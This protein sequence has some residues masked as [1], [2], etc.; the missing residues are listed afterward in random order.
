MTFT[1]ANIQGKQTVA[2]PT[3]A[4]RLRQHKHGQVLEQE[5]RNLST[6]V[7]S[8]VAVQVVDKNGNPITEGD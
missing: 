2:V 6:G 7:L 5:W 3:G 4:L 1:A 8:W